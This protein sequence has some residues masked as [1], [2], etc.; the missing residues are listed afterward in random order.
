VFKSVPDSSTRLAMLKRGEVDVAYLL[1][2]PQA[3]EVKRDPRQVHDR[4]RFASIYD[5][6]WPSG[7][8]PRVE[9]AALMMIDPYPWAAPVEELRLKAR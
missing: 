8:G 2:A 6:I 4:V 9:N 7:I 5:Y 1:D 3:Q